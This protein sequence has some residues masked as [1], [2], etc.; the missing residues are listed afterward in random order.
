MTLDFRLLGPF[1]VL[2]AQSPL[3][4]GGRKQRRLLGQLALH[5]GATVS[6]DD[7]VDAVWEDDAPATAGPTL[8]AYVSRIRGLLAPYVEGD[9]IVSARSGGYRLH[10]PSEWIDVHR[11]EQ[12][13]ARGRQALA[14]G[15]ADR[16]RD[17]LREAAE[18]WRGRLLCDVG[19][20]GPLRADSHRLDVAYESVLDAL[21]DAELACG[22]HHDVLPALRGRAAAHPLSERPHLQLMRALDHCGE[23]AEAL[24][25]YAGF[26]RAL[27]EELGVEPGT[28]LQAL[29]QRLLAARTAGRRPGNLPGALNSLVGREGDLADLE[30]LVRAY[31]LVTLT[32][33][34]GSGKTRLAFELARSLADDARDGTW[35]VEFAGTSEPGDVAQTVAKALNVLEQPGRDLAET[36][37]DAIADRELL[38]VFDNCEHLATACAELVTVLLRAAPSV[39]ILATSHEPLGIDG[40]HVHRLAPLAVPRADASRAELTSAPSVELFLQRAQA[41]RRDFTISHDNEAAVR[42]VCRELDG[43]PL[44][45]ELAAATLSAVDIEEVARRLP[46]RFALL[47]RGPRSAPARHRS[48]HAAVDWGYELLGADERDMFHQLSVFAGGFTVEAAERVCVVKAPVLH[49]LATLVDKSFVQFDPD[50]GRYRLLETLRLH[51]A[52]K[53]AGSGEEDAVRRRHAEHLLELTGR[54]AGELRGPDQL[55]WVDRLDEESDGIAAALRWSLDAGADDIALGLVANLWW[56]W[57][58]NGH[59]PEG[60]RWARQVLSRCSRP[61]ELRAAA[62]VG[63]AHLAWKLGEFDECDQ[64]CAEALTLVSSESLP[65]PLAPAARGVLAMVARDKGDLERASA[66]LEDV[67]GDYV[68]SGERWGEAATLNMIVSVDRDASDLAH[69]SALLERSSRLFAELGDQWGVAWSAWLTGRV[70]TR[71]GVDLEL[72]ASQLRHSIVLADELRHRFGVVLGLAGLAG[73]AAARGDHVQAARMLGATDALEQAMGVPVRAIERVDS[74][75]DIAATRTALG[76]AVYQEHWMAG[77]R[78]G[79]E[80]ALGEALSGR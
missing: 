39:T 13:A 4:L 56:Y 59:I 77:C 51:G 38:L 44:A 5:A 69:A 35:V 57:W 1:E 49:V 31:R 53:L 7:L 6:V 67:L 36:I 40:E 22:R 80:A 71:R 24:R 2:V 78:L 30:R 14:G 20:A 42:Q 18:H 70:E 21:F 3:A 73:V 46:D 25:A 63:T 48:L 43:L 37:G 16:A 61:P 23:Q 72:A 8:Q 62:L 33:P 11:F 64:V 28:E 55:S 29:H 54:A 79:P 66:L 68:S 27:R 50:R 52:D 32:G 58:R 65:G 47:S 75:R 34:G 19:V 76:P 45:L 9:A 10:V 74:A 12:L 26:R 41:A 60:A 17:L 15:D